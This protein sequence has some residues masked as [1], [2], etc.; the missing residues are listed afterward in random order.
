M[1][2]IISVQTCTTQ[3]VTG[4]FDS[5]E[6]SIQRKNIGLGSEEDMM[7]CS[8]NLY[9]LITFQGQESWMQVTKIASSLLWPR[10]LILPPSIALVSGPTLPS[11]MMRAGG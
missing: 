10:V 9:T 6:F 5:T 7:S 11:C 3:H 4:N 2:T 8:N 1:V